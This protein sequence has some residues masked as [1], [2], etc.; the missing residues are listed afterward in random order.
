[1]LVYRSVTPSS[2]SVS[3][4]SDLPSLRS[5]PNPGENHA[6]FGWRFVHLVLAVCWVGLKPSDKCPGWQGKKSKECPKHPVKNMMVNENA[7]TIT[8]WTFVLGCSWIWSTLVFCDS[9]WKN[10]GVLLSPLCRRAFSDID[11]IELLRHGARKC[12]LTQGY[13]WREAVQETRL[14]GILFFWSRYLQSCLL[15]FQ[16]HIRIVI[17]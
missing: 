15:S 12:M 6:Q 13:T 7:W 3:T 10:S 1:M 5:L 4:G 2:E 9:C 14:H 16:G 17:Q 8:F 11:L